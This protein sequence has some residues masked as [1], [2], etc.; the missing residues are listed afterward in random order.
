MTKKPTL[1][2]IIEFAKK[3]RTSNAD[4]KEIVEDCLRRENKVY[5]TTG[6]NKAF[7]KNCRVAGM[8]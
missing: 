8:F 7:D 5:D 4:L 1:K 3:C 6:S 2:K